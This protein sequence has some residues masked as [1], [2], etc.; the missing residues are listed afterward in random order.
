MM[1]FSYVKFLLAIKFKHGQ[2]M[3]LGAMAETIHASHLKL[4]GVV[5]LVRDSS[6]S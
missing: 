1:K 6:H 4:D 5:E 2:L 3:L